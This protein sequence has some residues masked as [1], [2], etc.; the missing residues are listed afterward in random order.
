MDSELMAYIIAIAVIFLTGPVFIT[1][2]ALF[3]FLTYPKEANDDIVIA[4]S[5]KDP[6]IDRLPNK[7][8]KT[9]KRRRL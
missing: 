3:F 8:T 6:T 2:L 1:L 9:S 5:R 4:D 7:D